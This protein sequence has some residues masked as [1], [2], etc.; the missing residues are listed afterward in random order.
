MIGQILQGKVGKGVTLYAK[1]D[2]VKVRS[3]F[4]TTAAV[5]L[6]FN[7]MQPLGTTT[8]RI[9][10]VPGEYTWFELDTAKGKG[11]VRRDVLVSKQVTVNIPKAETGDGKALL[12]RISKLDNQTYHKLLYCRE[13]IDRLQK[14]GIPIPAR[15]LADYSTVTSSLNTRQQKIKNTSGLTVAKGIV[16]DSFSWLQEK[17]S[18][19]IGIAPIVIAP[20]WYV[21][22]GIALSITAAYLWSKFT[23]DEKA[24][25][26]D[27]AKTPNLAKALEA[28]DSNTKQAVLS[29]INTF[30]KENYE[31]GSS[32]TSLF[33]GAKG[34]LIIGA[35]LAVGLTVFNAKK[36]K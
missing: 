34:V 2:A 1:G 10:S 31:K 14:K 18:N 9:Y 28:L 36:G 17:W 3:S 11:W 32:D 21:V 7:N 27:L 4:S 16:N 26:L 6:T 22:T 8:G 35:G 29:E 24:A 20:V 23:S 30:G 13:L 12:Q 33:S 15:L 19:L 25:E 5:L